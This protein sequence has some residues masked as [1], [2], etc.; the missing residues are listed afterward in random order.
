[1]DSIL[2]V[3]SDVNGSCERKVAVP[4]RMFFAIPHASGRLQKQVNSVFPGLQIA[5]DDSKRCQSREIGG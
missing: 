3:L 4:F 1:M 2:T 5:V